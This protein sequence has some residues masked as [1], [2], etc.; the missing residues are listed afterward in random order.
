MY[1]SDV[2]IRTT[3]RDAMCPK[4][5]TKPETWSTGV[6]TISKEISTLGCKH[7]LLHT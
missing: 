7:K 4:L 6:G 5:K 3:F 1:F 2:L